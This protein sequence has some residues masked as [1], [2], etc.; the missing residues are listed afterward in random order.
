MRQ[1]SRVAYAP[2]AHLA[3]V[4]QVQAVLE[5]KPDVAAVYVRRI[6]GDTA[7]IEVTMRAVGAAGDTVGEHHGESERTSE[8][9]HKDELGLLGGFVAHPDPA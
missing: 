7:I 5:D 3:M 6:E 1:G 2:F 8:T 9:R 4:S